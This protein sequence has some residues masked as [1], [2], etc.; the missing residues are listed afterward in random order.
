MATQNFINHALVNGK[1]RKYDMA[2]SRR[3]DYSAL[4]RSGKIIYLGR[5]IIYKISG[6]RQNYTR[7]THLWKRTKLWKK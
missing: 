1:V 2:A 7:K 6:K 4:E 3:T 5:G